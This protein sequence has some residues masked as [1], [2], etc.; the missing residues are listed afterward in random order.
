MTLPPV[1]SG[2]GAEGAL[3]DQL[4]SVQNLLTL[5]MVMTE[6]GDDERIL[7][8]ASATVPS[9][10]P[11]HVDGVILTD[12]GGWRLTSGPC[13]EPAV[14]TDLQGQFAVLNVA[15]GA[16]AIV[17][18]FWAWAFSLRSGQGHFGFLLAAAE[19]QPSTYEQFLLRALAQQTGVALANARM[20]VRERGVAD[21]LRATNA[22]LGA[23]VAT[24][25]L[26]TAIR[27]RLAEAAV[28]GEGQDGI[29][30]AVHELTGYSV[31]IEDRHGNL[32]AW[33]GPA[34]PDPYPKDTP[35]NREALLRRVLQA[36]EP[37]WAD[38]RLL[39][40]ARPAGAALGLLALVDPER[41]VG[42]QGM[43]ALEQG[44]VMLAMD[45]ARLPSL[46]DTE[47]RIGRDLVDELLVGADA[48][49][50]LARAQALGYDLER[51]HRVLVVDS[52]GEGLE[53]DEL[54]LAVRLAARDTD[55]GSLLAPRSQ[56]VVLLSAL[57]EGARVDRPDGPWEQL[58][59][60]VGQR[61]GGRRCRVGVG[62][63][64]LRPVDFPRSYREARLA[65]KLQDTSGEEDRVTVFDRLGVYRI[66]AEI[67]DT[68]TI[69]RFVLEWL[70][71]LLDYDAAK[72]TELVPTLT[73][74]LENGGNYDAT[75]KA[76]SVHRSTLKYRL[77]R[78]REISGLDLADPEIQFSLQLATRARDTLTAVRAR[79]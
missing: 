42:E 16:V 77:Q 2:P 57:K 60:A 64:C 6:S 12:D 19:L 48:E 41:V 15:G 3:K 43:T 55:A 9:L 79:S 75:A 29:A 11:C 54:L 71:P 34:R 17:G 44:A 70:G 67:P 26:R 30:R 22:T 32:R 25:Q 76:L 18:E 23:T 53:E 74:Y 28:A 47:L 49:L 73:R 45:L 66:L 46:A 72:R 36:G 59:A 10:G 24:I 50:A 56:W 37:I 68:G 21:E 62:G 58:R 20:H 4:S 8:L 27:D 52:P 7:Q 65:L 5:S 35:T 39:A 38:G 1:S 61:L 31:A 63:R 14:R 13:T 33:A 51:P 78:I 40:V 69:E